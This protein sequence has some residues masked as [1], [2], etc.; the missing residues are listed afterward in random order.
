MIIKEK[1][2]GKIMTKKT[3]VLTGETKHKKK[4]EKKLFKKAEMET[5][6]GTIVL[7]YLEMMVLEMMKFV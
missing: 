6:G 3:L 5:A 4:K 7:E 1:Q 2:E